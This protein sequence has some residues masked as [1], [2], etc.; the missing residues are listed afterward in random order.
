[1]IYEGNSSADDGDIEPT[2]TGSDDYW[3]TFDGVNDYMNITGDNVYK[4]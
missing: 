1:M 2:Y 3:Y 4:F